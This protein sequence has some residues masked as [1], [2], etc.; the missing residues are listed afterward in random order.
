[1][2]GWSGEESNGGIEDGTGERKD[3]SPP[4][5][6]RPFQEHIEERHR[7]HQG[8]DEDSVQR[9]Q[10]V[11]LAEDLRLTELIHSAFAFLFVPRAVIVD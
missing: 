11:E 2:I 3:E 9:T 4:Q 5:H 7:Q 1:V 6:L 10:D 8:Q